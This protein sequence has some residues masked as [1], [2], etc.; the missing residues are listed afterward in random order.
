MAARWWY[1][2]PTW[3]GLSLIASSKL[4]WMGFTFSN[5]LK[6]TTVEWEGLSYTNQDRNHYSGHQ[7]A[8]CSWWEGSADLQID[9]CGSEEI[10]L[11]WWQCVE[12]YAEKVATG[13]PCAI[14]QAESLCYRLV[15]PPPSCA[16]GLLWYAAVLPGEWGQRL[17]GGSVW[18]T[19]RTEGWIHAWLSPC[20]WPHEPQ[21]GPLSYYVE[22]AAC[23]VLFR[24]GVLGVKGK[25]VLPWDPI[26]KTGP[27]KPLPP[28][29]KPKVKHCPPPSSLNRR[30]GSLSRLHAPA[31]THSKIGL[32]GHWIWSLDAAL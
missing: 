13:G 10:W 22:P 14:A 21:W 4:D 8:E 7:D 29:W 28:L 6:M 27:Q 17:Q 30:V 5:C 12:L 3:R 26:S 32:L 19:L 23:P 24:Q 18:E 31:G 25:S 2:F 16:A 9:C 1:R 11:P 15:G 20:R